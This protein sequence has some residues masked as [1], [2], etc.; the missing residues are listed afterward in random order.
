MPV[1]LPLSSAY[2]STANNARKT[3]RNSQS[4]ND[5]PRVTSR[6]NSLIGWMLSLAALSDTPPVGLQVAQGS[7]PTGG[8]P[9]KHDAPAPVRDIP[10]V[11]LTHTLDLGLQAPANG[12]RQ[13]DHTVLRP[14]P[15][16]NGNDIPLEVDVLHT[17]I[18][19]LAQP[20]ASPVQEH[21]G[22]PGDAREPRKNRPDLAPIEQELRFRTRLDPD[23][24]GAANS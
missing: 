1:P 14:F 8:S 5:Q 19:A 9:G 15:L 10:S 23:P 20:K 17:Q 3:L 7:Q 4:T 21:P 22:Q 16:S 2:D 13:R 18:E 24:S 12:R 6:L 11:L